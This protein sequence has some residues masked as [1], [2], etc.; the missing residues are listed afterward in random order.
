[1]EFGEGVIPTGIEND[2][3]VPVFGESVDG[4]SMSIMEVRTKGFGDN[5]FCSALEDSFRQF[6][7]CEPFHY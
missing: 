4:F 6:G 7:V 1:M 2:Q 3:V 5:S